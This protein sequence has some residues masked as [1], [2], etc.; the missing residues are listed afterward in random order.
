MQSSYNA[1]TTKLAL[2]QGIDIGSDEWTRGGLYAFAG[3]TGGHPA[4]GWRRPETMDDAR[5]RAVISNYAARSCYYTDPE[6]DSEIQSGYR[7][8]GRPVGWEPEDAL[9][10]PSGERAY[11]SNQT[12][13]IT[14]VSG[15]DPMHFWVDPLLDV[16]DRAGD[17]EVPTPF[18]SQKATTVARV[19]A[20]AHIDSLAGMIRYQGQYWGGGRLFARVVDT[21]VQANKRAGVV[22]V[23]SATVFLQWLEHYG[24]PAL[25]EA[26]GVTNA[27]GVGRFNIYQDISW[28]LPALYD[29]SNLAQ[30]LT[31]H[32]SLADRIEQR[33]QQVARWALD[34]D[35]VK[36]GSGGW[37]DCDITGAML[38]GN[39]GKTLDTLEG[40]I[41]AE[42]VHEPEWYGAWA[43]RAADIVRRLIPGEQSEDYYQRV[44]AGVG[45]SPDFK[46]WLVD[47]DRNWVE[48]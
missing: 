29:L 34:I 24:L 27:K 40:V 20:R 30:A 6:N 31:G 36:G 12:P 5:A 18:D 3:Q 17:I 19:L 32:V 1:L 4:Y 23:E 7:I 8:A 16:I 33:K 35:A 21:F 28:V 25:E 43:V 46:P 9:D 44:L 47:A 37:S 42:N 26:P 13:T 22:S 10:V 14:L 45:P 48:L 38:V 41:T 11:V 2:M 39:D 15:L